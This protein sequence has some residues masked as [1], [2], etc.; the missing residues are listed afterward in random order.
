MMRSK[1]F[2][3]FRRPLTPRGSVHRPK[4]GPGSYRREDKKQAVREGLKEWIIE[5]IEEDDEYPD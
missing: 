5:K 4:K 2:K 3:G 1:D